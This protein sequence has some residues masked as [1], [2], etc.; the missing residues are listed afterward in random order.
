MTSR[1]HP[2][3][4]QDAGDH[5]G[6]HFSTIRVIAERVS[7]ITQDSDVAACS[8]SMEYCCPVMMLM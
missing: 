1:V 3:R 6:F 5:L 7:E 4:L 2:S 8:F